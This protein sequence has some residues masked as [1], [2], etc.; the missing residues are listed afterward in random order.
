MD[1]ISTITHK[2]IEVIFSEVGQSFLPPDR[3]FG[4]TEKQF[5]KRDTILE[6]S[7]YMNILN[8]NATLVEVGKECPVT[9]WKEAV[10]NVVKNAGQW[11]VR[12]MKCKRDETNN[13]TIVSVPK[14]KRREKYTVAFRG[15]EFSRV[16]KNL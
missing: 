4:R 14:L 11:H 5:R 16:R 8:E 10:K 3:V 9:N 12:F 13:Y 1:D 15:G 2:K 7:D 6:P